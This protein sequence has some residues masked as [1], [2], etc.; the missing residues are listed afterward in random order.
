MSVIYF[1][2]SAD[3]LTA[4]RAPDSMKEAFS[5]LDSGT[6]TRTASG[7]MVRSVLRGGNN[8]IRKIEL[9]WS[10]LNANDARTIL[11]AVRSSFFYMKYPDVLTGDFRTAQ[12]YAGDK[13]VEVRRIESGGKV[14]VQNLSFSV[15]ER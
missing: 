14:M 7:K 6:T 15:I 1:G 5:D 2:T 12:F 3:S 13:T 4:V 8:S 9:S 11:R 10:L